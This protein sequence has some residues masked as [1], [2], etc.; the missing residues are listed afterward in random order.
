MIEPSFLGGFFANFDG[1][2]SGELVCQKQG[3]IRMPVVKLQCDGQQSQLL[4]RRF[5]TAWL[6]LDFNSLASTAPANASFRR[7][8]SD[9]S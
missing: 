2:K 3:W 7:S 5:G 9:G 6:F 8:L 4:A 1:T